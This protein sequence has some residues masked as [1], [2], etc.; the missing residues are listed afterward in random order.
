MTD[1]RVEAVVLPGEHAEVVQYPADTIHLRA[2]GRGDVQ[3]ADY[4]SS[5]RGGP[6]RHS[7]PWV[8][9]QIVVDGVVEFQIG[10]DP[11]VRGGSGTVQLLPKGIPHTLRIPEGS[12]R[13]IQVS[14]G[15]PYDGFAREMARLFTAKA[16]LAE[17]V[18]TAGKHGV[19]L[20]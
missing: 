18:A 5:D 14:I 4:V 7:H 13:I 9:A 3:V 16:P 2:V 11:W 8:E 12:A 20:A 15:P 17:I 1:L 19:E 6:P 10:T